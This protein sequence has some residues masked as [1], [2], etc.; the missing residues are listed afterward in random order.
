[1]GK[2]KNKDLIY[3]TL[4]EHIKLLNSLGYEIDEKPEEI[5]DYNSVNI[6]KGNIIIGNIAYEEKNMF[7]LYRD[8]R[9][10]GNRD[11]SKINFNKSKIKNIR[12]VIH[13][14]LHD[15]DFK[16][17]GY[18]QLVSEDRPFIRITD[19]K[20]YQIT[21]Y[22]NSDDIEIISLNPDIPDDEILENLRKPN[23]KLTYTFKGV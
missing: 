22:I 14:K 7:Y 16:F 5:I 23:K 17:N 21:K 18:N 13:L 12:G 4:D 20:K 1:M 19:C 10:V 3:I 6:Y 11:L 2:D 9:I 15:Y 8:K